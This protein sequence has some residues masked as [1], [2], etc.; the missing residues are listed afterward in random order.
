MVGT[1]LR[2]LRRER[3]LLL[4]HSAEALKCSTSVVARIESGRLLPASRD[5]A[6]LLRRY[7]FPADGE[8]ADL[9]A[10]LARG[11]TAS[12]SLAFDEERGWIGRLKACESMATSI[13]TYSAWG[14]PALVHSPEYAAHWWRNSA[15]PNTPGSAGIADRALPVDH[16]KDLIVL[17]EESV[18]MRACDAREVMA[19][20]L[21][22]LITMIEHS[23]TTLRIVPMAKSVPPP[24]GTL[25]E[26]CLGSRVLHVEESIG[27]MYAT[28][29]ESRKLHGLIEDALRN[30]LSEAE[31]L[32]FL[33]EAR[34]SC[35]GI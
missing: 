12:A 19:G 29:Q 25:I 24:R 5:V 22:H 18:L 17:L 2:S 35:G 10:A 26:L 4:R 23:G 7:G 3:D 1:Y 14:L 15:L 32:A 11:N 8:Q 30:S 13:V 20:Q 21:A 33:R 9:L 6:R 16:D 28:G 27:A 31:S 34:K